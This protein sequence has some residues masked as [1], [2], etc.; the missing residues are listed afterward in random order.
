VGWLINRASGT[1]AALDMLDSPLSPPPVAVIPDYA[2]PLLEGC[3]SVKPGS[4][5][6]IGKTQAVPFIPA[7]VGDAMPADK[8]EKL[9]K[10]LLGTKDGA[11]SRKQS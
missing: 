2:L 3:G 4:L 7:F 10:V 1:E 11:K 8:Q 5:R 9:L 6:V